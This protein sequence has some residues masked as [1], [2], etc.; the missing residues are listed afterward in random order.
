[1]NRQSIELTDVQVCDSEGWPYV[2]SRW[3]HSS[4]G[5]WESRILLYPNDLLN[6]A[7][8]VL[9]IEVGLSESGFAS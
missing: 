8:S 6:A 5:I 2:E 3:L 1:M 4:R 9:M 7:V